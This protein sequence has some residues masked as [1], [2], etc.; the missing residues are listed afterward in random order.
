MKPIAALVS[1]IHLSAKAPIARSEEKDWI[2]TQRGYLQQWADLKE[3]H[4]VRGIIAGDIFDHW[5]GTPELINMAS[6]YIMGDFAIPGQ[7]DLP[8][9]NYHERH[10]SAYGV[11]EK[12]GIIRNLPPKE[13]TPVGPFL[14]VVGFPWGFEIAPLEEKSKKTTLCVAHAFCWM[15]EHTY[16]GAEKSKNAVAYAKKLKGFDAAVFGDNHKGFLT[17]KNGIHILNNGGFMRRN[18]DQ[19][20]YQPCMGLLYEDGSI[21]RVEVYCD[22][23]VFKNAQELAHTIGKIQE[24]EVEQF[25]KDMRQLENLGLDFEQ[26]L[27]HFCETNEVSKQAKNLILKFIETCH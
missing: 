5:K 24:I 22:D 27:K 3:T 19:I 20:N 13:I 17:N 2:A 14:E 11:L 25:V 12:L 21:E 18:S 16:P 10:K 6:E 8:Y 26:A 9:H 1:D 23:D 7:H 15:K 4:N